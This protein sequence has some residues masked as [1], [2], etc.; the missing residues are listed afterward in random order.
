MFM[1]VLQSN[2]VLFCGK[3]SNIS[4]N[5][6]RRRWT[7]EEEQSGQNITNIMEKKIA[8]QVVRVAES[9]SRLFF[10]SWATRPDSLRSD[11]T[12]HRC[13]KSGLLMYLERRWSS[14]IKERRKGK[15]CNYNSRL[16]A[17][18]WITGT[19]CW[20]DMCLRVECLK[21]NERQGRTAWGW[22]SFLGPELEKQACKEDTIQ[23]QWTAL[24]CVATCNPCAHI[25]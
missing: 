13:W 6:F 16:L 4:G 5:D 14:S 1:S 8:K 19:V 25:I 11:R 9:V 22:S 2:A 10:M 12:F 18:R 17:V 3:H 7:K 21:E 24:H 23:A 20:N 15:V